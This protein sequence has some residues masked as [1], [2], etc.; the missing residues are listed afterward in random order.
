MK[1]ALIFGMI[2]GLMA[3]ICFGQQVLGEY[4]WSKV[5]Q[6][7]DLL[8]GVPMNL[9]GKSVLKLINT[10]DTPLQVHLIKM[11]SPKIT[12]EF[13]AVEGQLKYEGVR[14]QGYLEMWNYFPA[15]KAGG[16][17]R[18]YFSRTL[19]AS[20]D[21]GQI[22][23]TTDWRRFMLPFNRTGAGAP[24]TRLEINLFL[25]S[26]GTVYLS[27]VKLVQYSSGFGAASTRSDGAWWSER[28]GGLIGGFTGGSLGCLAGLLGWL[29]SQGKARQFVVPATKALIALGALS[30]A[31]G[32]V[33]LAMRQPLGVWSVLLLIGV[34]LLAILPGRLKHFNRF[35][36]NLEIRKMAALDA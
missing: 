35:Y 22:T 10:N 16:P 1:K 11:L 26:Q 14:G 34:I 12:T 8:G 24:P 27:S 5:A 29:A 13:Y 31:A 9:D 19:G 28:A 4:D 30:T 25:P 33:A 15:E 20:G 21:M 3:G 7:G 18:G 32:L 36:E 2:A 23:G 17:E 6:K